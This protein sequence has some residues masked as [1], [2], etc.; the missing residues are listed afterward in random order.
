MSDTFIPVL[1]FAVMSDIH[2][3]AGYPHVR[4]RFASAMR[5]IYAYADA[6]PTY[7]GLD[8]LY[9]VGDVINRGRASEYLLL[10]EDLEKNVRQDTLTVI[11]LGGHD[12][13]D[14][15]VAKDDFLRIIGMPLDRH[16][17]IHGYHFVSLSTERTTGPWSDSFG[18][19]KRAFL[20][21]SL[22][23]ATAADPTRPIFVFQH[24]GVFDTIGGG[25][26][27]NGELRDILANY[28]AVVDFSGHSHIPAN[29]PEETYKGDFTAVSTG[30]ILEL[31]DASCVNEGI[32]FEEGLPYAHCLVVE[33]DAA[34][35]VRIR[36]FD[37]SAGEFFEDDV[38]VKECYKKESKVYHTAYNPAGHAPAFPAHAALRI[39]SAGEKTSLV[40]PA[41]VGDGERVK[42][43]TVTL[44]DNAGH[45]LSE[46]NV[47]SDYA[48]CHMR[49]TVTIPL[50]DIPQTPFCAEVRPFGFHDDVGKPLT[51]RSSNAAEK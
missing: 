40:F 10:K 11:T 17:V 18:E 7:T 21:R 36:H 37:I 3:S 6:H 1:R 42:G 45:M 9:L 50:T 41:A 23:E 2:E 25:F 47:I 34:H 35:T 28:P 24:P 8:A 39:V 22:E 26:Y 31:R 32:P 46:K 43:Y 33:V 51:V 15:P 27:G 14:S 38:I 30:G 48:A 19:E 20:R 5:D 12:I 49:D 29:S 16:E 13:H 44:R 4:E